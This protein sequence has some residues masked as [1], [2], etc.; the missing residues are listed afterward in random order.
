MVPRQ[1][2]LYY[3]APGESTAL[4]LCCLSSLPQTGE[5]QVASAQRVPE[6]D[7]ACGCTAPSLSFLIVSLPR[8]AMG[9]IYFGQTTSRHATR[10]QFDDIFDLMSSSLHVASKTQQKAYRVEHYGREDALRNQNSHHVLR[11]RETRTRTERTKLGLTRS[12]RLR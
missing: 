5:F 12:A 1:R 2:Y 8:P 9:R 3:C 10:I 11:N 4:C 6:A 7:S